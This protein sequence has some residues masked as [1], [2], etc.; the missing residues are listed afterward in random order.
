[1][2]DA[3]EQI[4]HAAAALPE[5]THSSA[6]GRDDDSMLPDMQPLPGSVDQDANIELCF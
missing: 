2:T 1:M 4:V 6:V 3:T 5:L